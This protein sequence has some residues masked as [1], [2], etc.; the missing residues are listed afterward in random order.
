LALAL[1]LTAC[2]TPRPEVPAAL[3]ACPP[4]ADTP[5]PLGRLVTPETLR[6]RYYAER[7]ARLE[8]QDSLAACADQLARVLGLLAR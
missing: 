8:D 2:V 3:R 4:A 5:P 7:A 1:L 6:A